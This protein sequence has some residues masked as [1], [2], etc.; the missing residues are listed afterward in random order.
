MLDFI[1][2][3]WKSDTPRNHVLGFYKK[4]KPIHE[5]NCRKWYLNLMMQRGNQ[6]SAYNESGIL[7]DYKTP[8]WR[9]K[10]TSNK[11][12]P[13]TIMQLHNFMPNNPTI[14]VRPAN[15][16]SEQDKT[17]SDKSKQLLRALWKDKKFK[18]QLKKVIRWMI[19]CTV[20]YMLPIWDGRA[21]TKLDEDAYTGELIYE[22]ASPFEIIPDFAVDDFDE[23]PRFI[24]MKIR[25]VDYVEWKYGH[26]VKPDKLDVNAIYQIKAA[27]L[28][29]GIDISEKSI[30]EDQ[31]IIYEMFELP[32]V[33]NPE[34]FH[35][36]CT[37]NKDLI[38]P[39]NMEPYYKLSNG[40]KDFFLPLKVAQSITLPGGLIGTNSLEQASPAQVSFNKG[41]SDI[42][43]NI[44]GFGRIRL[45]APK[46]KIPRGA[47]VDNP[48]QKILETDPDVEGDVDVLKPPE[49]ANYH[50]DFIRKFV[51]E[52]QDL[53]GIH[54][55]TQGVLPRRA[56]SGKAINFLIG[57]DDKRAVDPKEEI[58]DL[59]SGVM[60]MGLNIA[61]NGYSEERI[62]DLIGD[63]DE[64][65]SGKI[66]GEELRNIDVTVVRDTALPKDSASRL[67]LA[68]AILER[69]P[70]KDDIEVMFAIMEADN[71]DNLKAILSGN[72][73]AEE[74]YARMENF[75]MRKGIPREPVAGE[76]HVM[77][78][79]IHELVL[80]DP[81]TMPEVRLLV[82]EHKL[83][84]KQQAGTEAANENVVDAGI[85]SQ[86]ENPEGAT[87]APIA[88]SGNIP[89]I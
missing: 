13:L 20:G 76:N 49:M 86:I 44:K 6:W 42:L 7:R 69:K 84:H 85:Q 79:K 30:L 87:E 65:Y 16:N 46:G 8:S 31:V 67:E 29:A 66:Q 77:H 12:L 57:Q 41:N 72:S 17:K 83:K 50:L 89:K 3:L 21:G 74:I 54:D 19:P 88:V 56:T 33:K 63:D 24:R 15:V 14:T 18:K 10:Y 11:L 34:G 82:I 5:A 9:V 55:A 1:S 73:V 59:I 23:M 68:M 38:K 40:Q 70:T 52:M 51:G 58:D 48:A 71:F 4:Q 32:S 61:A 45:I 28:S 78:D 35:H 80:K 53:F 22:A 37:E 43:E 64:M 25:S 27:Q 47:M 36:I 75:D 62:K 2:N 81:N 26:R 39:G 60:S